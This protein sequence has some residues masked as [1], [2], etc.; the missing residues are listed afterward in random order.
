MKANANI[1]INFETKLKLNITFRLATDAACVYVQ[2]L[3]IQWLCNSEYYIETTIF[4]MCDDLH[5]GGG[6]HAAMHTYV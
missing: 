1:D 5:C 6:L 4:S 2:N 3:L